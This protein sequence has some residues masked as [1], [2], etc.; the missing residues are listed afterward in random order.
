MNPDDTLHRRARRA[1]ELGRLYAALPCALVAPPLAFLAAQSCPRS[2]LYLAFLAALAAALLV[3]LRWRGQD[4][5]RAVT[6]GV[7]MGLA[8][9]AVPW[10]AVSCNLC[11]LTPS[12]LLFGLCGAGGATSGL[13]LS[14]HCLLRGCCSR[15]H[16]LSA[17]TA[18]GLIAAMGCAPA[19]FGGLVGMALALALTGAPALV[20]RRAV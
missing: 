14:A 19:G 12:P 5:G 3:G 11:P 6:P 20:F 15:E 2:G 7:L 17:G 4:F 9:Y 10:L 1:Y 8:G 18:A 13:A 16:V